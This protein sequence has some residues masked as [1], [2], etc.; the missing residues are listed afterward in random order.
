MRRATVTSLMLVVVAGCRTENSAPPVGADGVDP[1]AVDRQTLTAEVMSVMDEQADPCQ[2][3][4]AYACGEWLEQ[5]EIPD[6]QS[7]FGRFHVLREQN[8]QTQREILASLPVSAGAG[9]E[10]K[11]A[12]FWNACMDEAAIE[13]RGTEPLEEPLARIAAIEDRASLL[14]AVGRFHAN[15]MDV[16]MSTGVSADYK[17]PDLNILH[18]S[19]GGL[20]LPDRDYYLREGAEADKLRELYV[21][22]VATMLRLGGDAK[23]EA[24]AAAIVAFETALAEA[25]TPRDQLR[26]PEK[27]YNRMDRAALGALTPTLPWTAFFEGLGHPGMKQLNV[28]PTDFFTKIEKLVAET[29]LATMQAYL[30]W[31]LVRD[32]AD[33]LPQAFVDASFAFYGQALNGQKALSPRWK[34]CVTMTDGGLGEALGRLFVDRVFG[35]DSKAIASTMIT[36]IED[37][38]AAGLPSLSWMDDATRQR[39]L[40]KMHAV[41]NKI[42]YPDKWRDY[43]AVEVG[44]DHFGNVAA[45]TEFEI[46]RRLSEVGAPVDQAEWHMTPSTVNAY[47]NP[48]NNEMVFPAGILQRPFFD[49]G[50]PMAMNFGGIGM[51]MGHELTHGFDDQGRKYDGEGRLVQWWDDAVVASFEG[52]A[53]CVDNLYSSYEVQ[54]GVHLNG[55]LTLGENIADL[56][57]IKQSFRAYETW[58]EANV[59]AQTAVEGL[60]DEQLFFVSFG[61]IWCTKATQE[62]ERV[63][64]LTDPH[65]HPRY[66]VNGPLANMSEFWETFSCEP[67]TPMH[68]VDVCEVW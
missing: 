50:Y 42:G 47:Y 46:S 59:A 13:S 5:T 15:G 29:D 3:F 32:S 45:V 30:R 58:A 12:R 66:R 54:P 37:A 7:R 39:A 51:V 62:A 23:P 48:S 4:Y 60:S 64:A 1:A 10:A 6:D 56:G 44:S 61:Q 40:D 22:H 43:T 26:D 63:L 41:V 2:D 38:F 20:G 53:E 36:Q 28:S 57:G 52:R 16:L 14:E 11:L 49:A 27:L 9:D 67:G 33:H 55:A 31:H 24:S 25:S 65:S 21:E 34:R 35:G 8:L 19:Q 17:E 68:P 18:I